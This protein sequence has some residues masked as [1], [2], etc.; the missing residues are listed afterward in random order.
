MVVIITS[1]KL[2]VVNTKCE[3]HSSGSTV[4]KV[5]LNYSRRLGWDKYAARLAMEQSTV[6][7]KIISSLDLLY[8]KIQIKFILTIINKVIIV[9]NKYINSSKMLNSI[10][11]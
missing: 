11:T 5:V 1:S 8:L 7:P 4:F 10:I 3:Y 9:I 2:R 6:G